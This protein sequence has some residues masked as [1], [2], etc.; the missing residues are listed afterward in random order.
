MCGIAG[1]VSYQN[2]STYLYEALTVLQHRGQDAAGI[3]TCYYRHFHLRKSNGLVRDVFRN[4][5]M[6]SLRGNMGIGHVRY[7]TAGSFDVAEAQPFYT[8]SPYGI[9]LAHNG[10]LTNASELREALF[11]KE[12][13]HLNTESD[14]EI[15]LNVIAHE[16]QTQH[17][18]N[19]LSAENLFRAIESVHRRCRGGY[20]AVGLIVGYGLFAFRDP[21]G[22]RPLVLGQRTDS[23]GKKEYMV[24]SESVALSCTGF[25]LVRDIAPGEAIYIDQ[26]GGLHHQQCAEKIQLSPCLFEYVY[27][28]RP[29][30]VI[31]GISVY[32]AR[33]SMGR[34]LAE[35]IRKEWADKDIDVVIPVPDSGRSTALELARCLNLPYREGFVKNRYIGRTF[36]MSEQKTR[37]SAVRRKLNTI[38]TEFEGKNVLILDDSVVR[39]TTCKQIIEMARESG[40]VKVYFCSAAPAVRYPNVYGIDMPVADELVAHNRTTEDVCRFIGADALLYQDLDVM[41]QV[42]KKNQP[43]IERFD[44]AV[45]DGHYVTGDISESYLKKLAEER[46][47]KIK[48]AKSIK[49]NKLYC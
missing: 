15:L 40:A 11:C 13:R 8:N 25:D 20:A 14:S 3:A 45:F 35:K 28:A 31:D 49:E 37:H 29:D 46:S 32:D 38:N 10:N 2:V 34:T 43:H 30:S 48:A 17:I 44:S 24:A 22:I 16:L 26:H 42:L 36:I 33:V 19:D 4:R 9:M 39:G 27:M 18:F 47:D 1:I 21:F 12:R 7:P 41:V 23:Q 6:K 5:H